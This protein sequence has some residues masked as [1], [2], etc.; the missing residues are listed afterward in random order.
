MTIMD[1]AKRTKR[2]NNTKNPRRFG[3]RHWQ[4]KKE[5]KSEKGSGKEH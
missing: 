3:H 2:G 4:E 1:I 5:R